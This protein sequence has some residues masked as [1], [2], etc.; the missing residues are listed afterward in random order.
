MG[1]VSLLAVP[2]L[3]ATAQTVTTPETVLHV[4]RSFIY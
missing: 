1:V 2:N 4:M 3:D